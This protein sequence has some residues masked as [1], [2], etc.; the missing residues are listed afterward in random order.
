LQNLIKR[1]VRGDRK[2]NRNTGE[3]TFPVKAA[4]EKDEKG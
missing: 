1:R 4:S 3:G 2:E